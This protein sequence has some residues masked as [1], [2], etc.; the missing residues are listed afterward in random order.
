MSSRASVNQFGEKEQ[1]HRESRIANC[2]LK[3]GNL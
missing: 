3:K 2:E 1:K